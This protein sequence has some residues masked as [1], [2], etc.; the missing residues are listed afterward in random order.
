MTAKKRKPL[1]TL[2][3][4]FVYN[5]QEPVSV[6]ASA[7]TTAE[8]TPA[9]PKPRKPTASRENTLIKKLQ[10]FQKEPTIRFTVDLPE[11]LHGKLSAAATKAGCKKVDIVRMLLENGLK[12]IEV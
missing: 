3:E 5:A 4:Q 11:S 7:P 9:S 1:D 10:A 2:E 6:P 8:P 12:D